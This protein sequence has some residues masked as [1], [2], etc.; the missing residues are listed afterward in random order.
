MKKIALLLAILL[1]LGVCFSGCT[2]KSAHA[3]TFFFMDTVITV[4]LY[5]EDAELASRALADCRALLAELDTLWSPTMEQSD[6]VRFNTSQEPLTLDSRTA[7][8]LALA[9]DVSRKTNGAFDVTV[10]PLVRLWS[11]AEKNNLLPTVAQMQHTLTL[12]GYQKLTLTDVTLSRRESGV[13]IDLGGIGKGAAADALISL[14]SGYTL[15]GGLISFGSNIAT[16]GSKPDKSP[17]RIAL[18]DP[19]NAEISVGTLCLSDGQILSVSGDYERFVTVA[20]EKYHHILDPSVGYPANTGLASVAVV[21]QS[22][23][24]ADALSTAL[25]V[26]GWEAATAFYE[27][28]AYAFEAI[29][30]TSDGAILTTPGMTDIWMQN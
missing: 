1:T 19:K 17:F 2:R 27:S 29:V 5:T 6:V 26:M 20:G 16:F 25:F 3:A 7:E 14:L 8:L 24:L 21:C 12:C 13:E 15:E 18:R 9:L 22:G 4:T 28:G 11:E 30:V 23:A 10:A